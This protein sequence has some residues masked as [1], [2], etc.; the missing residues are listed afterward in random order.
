MRTMLSVALTLLGCW[1]A[2][3]LAAEPPAAE[4]RAM[5]DGKSLAGWEGKA[6]MFRVEQGAIVAGSLKEPISQNEFLCTE[7]EY[8]DFELRFEAKLVGE[9]TNAGVQFRSQ[10]IP[11]HHEVKGYQCDIG[12]GFGRNIWGSLYDESRR[13]QFLAHGD[14]QQVL[15][16]YKQDD[17]NRLRVRCQGPRVQ[18][19]LNDV[20][21]VDY[22]EQQPNIPQTGIIGLQIHSGKPTEAWYR[23]LEI[24]EL[25]K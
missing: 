21:T 22:R 4:F 18:I 23:N 13:R 20:Q 9:G 6:G 1:C 11:N 5:A 16:A 7:R 14:E 2:P 12:E 17:W 8:G 24:R 10:R 3:L 19:W 15:K 25:S